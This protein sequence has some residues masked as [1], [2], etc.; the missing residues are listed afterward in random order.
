MIVK[1]PYIIGKTSEDF[2]ATVICTP[3]DLGQLKKNIEVDYYIIDGFEYKGFVYHTVMLNIDNVFKFNS[4]FPSDCIKII[5]GTMT[6]NYGQM[7]TYALNEMFETMEHSKK[8][9]R[10]NNKYDIINHF[11]T[12]SKTGT[13]IIL[14]EKINEI[15]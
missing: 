11:D 3:E 14:I 5:P 8:E 9:M 2:P 13:K 12:F 6:I 15:R 7:L 4:L 1:V 10:K